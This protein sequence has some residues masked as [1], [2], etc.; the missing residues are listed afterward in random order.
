MGRVKPVYVFALIAVVIIAVFIKVSNP[1]RKYSTQAYWETATVQSV[2]DIP[3]EA[4]EPGNRNGPVLMW[5]AIAAKDPRIIEALLERGAD[6]NESDRVFKGTPLT[7]AAGYS[8]N[9]EVIDI[10]VENGA[11]VHMKVH[12]REDALMIA[13]QYNNNSELIERLLYHG[14]KADNK[15]S[16]GKTALD[17]AYR[18]ENIPAIKVLRK[19]N[20]SKES[21]AIKR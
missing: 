13:A 15:N 6:V 19:Y 9:A 11:D 12:N 18:N 10:L 8:S 3:Q 5:A 14:A 2:A 21:L 17:L 1:H 7:G 4:L 16:L 20:Q